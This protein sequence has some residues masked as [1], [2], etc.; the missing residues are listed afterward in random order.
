MNKFVAVLALMV[1]FSLAV[2]AGDKKETSKEKGGITTL[3]GYVV[4]A[5]CAKDMVGKED[6][7]TRAANHTKK[8]A[9]EEMCASSG[10]GVFSDGKWYKFDEAGDKQAKEL[11]DKT[12]KTKEIAVEVKGKK[13]DGTF[14]VTSIKEQKGIKTAKKTKKSKA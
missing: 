5:S 8:C 3:K 1:V 4:D 11:V 2:I 9:L 12:T 6:V 10:Y 13:G 14:A 7:M